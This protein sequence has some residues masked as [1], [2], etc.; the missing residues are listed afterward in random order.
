MITI[1]T[2]IEEESD[3]IQFVNDISKIASKFNYT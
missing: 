1:D 2:G 3:R